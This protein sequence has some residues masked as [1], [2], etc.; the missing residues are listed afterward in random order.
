M[1]EIDKIAHIVI[2]YC[3]SKGYTINPLKLQKLLYFV[4]AWHIVNFDKDTLFEELPEAWVNGPVYRS[5]YDIFKT[6]FY[7][8]DNF[9]TDYTEEKLSEEL[10]KLVRELKVTDKQQELIF[11]VLDVYG[12]MSDE[13]LVLSTHTAV[14][15]N[16]ARKGCKSFERCTNPISVDDMYNYYSKKE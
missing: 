16:N 13:K 12:A 3:Q 11:D 5:V 1:V 14:P 6:K 10:G 8:N 9:T 4:Q 7:R 2:L 15:W